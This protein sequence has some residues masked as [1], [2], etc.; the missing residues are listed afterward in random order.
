MSE[1]ISTTITESPL[2]AQQAAVLSDE[3]VFTRRLGP[4]SGRM[5]ISIRC[6][7]SA[8]KQ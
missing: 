6:N 8:R 2:A 4:F 5:L 1:P 3:G 7:P